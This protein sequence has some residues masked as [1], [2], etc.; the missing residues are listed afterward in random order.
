MR[1]GW[2]YRA[3]TP[4]AYD[5]AMR[6]IALPLL[7]LT[8]CGAAAPVPSR[9]PDDEATLAVTPIAEW[10][11]YVALR[12]PPVALDETLPELPELE[13][14]L[15]LVRRGRFADV[16]HSLHDV[17]TDEQRF[18]RE[19]RVAAH[20]LLARALH[21]LGYRAAALVAFEELLRMDPDADPAA[22]RWIARLVL[23]DGTDDVY[24]SE[25]AASVA[26]RL[27]P[28]APDWLRYVAG[29]ALHARGEADEAERALSEIE[30][31]SP[32]YARAMLV[33]GEIALRAARLGAA[34]QRFRV[35]ADGDAESETELALRHRARFALASVYF[36]RSAEHGRR[37]TPS[38]ARIMV[39]AAVLFARVDRSSAYAADAT[40]GRAWA[41]RYLG[42]ADQA[43]A[44]LSELPDAYVRAKPEVELMLAEMAFEACDP[45]SAEQRLSRLRSRADAAR[46]AADALLRRSG[47]GEGLEVALAPVVEGERE[48]AADLAGLVWHLRASTRLRSGLRRLARLRGEQH[49]LAADARLQGT[50]LG[51]QIGETLA[52]FTTFASDMVAELAHGIAYR[53]LEEL[54][55]V[56]GQ[57]ATLESELPALHAR[58]RSEAGQRLQ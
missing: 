36:Q 33:R 9:A 5:A 28:R 7:V 6:R 39:N 12:P 24:V 29:R 15:D 44:A 55:F 38:T 11:A 49:R 46:G 37:L 23:E 45:S 27:G 57:G 56:R 34:A 4:R 14:E 43:R 54:D 48:L 26:A 41:L 22:S 42:R 3:R 19:A 53:W 40:L 21:R 10:P 58:C 25:A 20:G 50:P 18:S 47:E 32:F 17:I 51:E 8:G 35:V 30:P 31:G 16:V 13:G 2:A 1:I 52:L